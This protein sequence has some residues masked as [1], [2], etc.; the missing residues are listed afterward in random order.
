MNHLA[1]FFLLA[2]V[3]ALVMSIVIC[4]VIDWKGK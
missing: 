2:S 4:I 3:Y 1:V